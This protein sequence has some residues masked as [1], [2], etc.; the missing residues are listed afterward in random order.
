MPRVRHLK[1]KF[2]LLAA[3]LR[4]YK[5]VSGMTSI[6]M[7]KKLGCTPE[8]VRAQIAKP[9]DKWRIGDLK[10]YCAVLGAPVEDVFQAAARS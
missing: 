2:N 3:T 9:A 10:R 6:D 1:P 7:A 4:E 8:N 5:R